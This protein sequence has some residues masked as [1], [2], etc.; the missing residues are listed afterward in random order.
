ML[1]EDGVPQHCDC[2]TGLM[3][4]IATGDEEPRVAAWCIWCGIG[5][6]DSGLMLLRAGQAMTDVAHL[7]VTIP[8]YPLI[9]KYDLWSPEC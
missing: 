7:E 4:T 5:Y 2:L 1:D 6:G 9:G 8:M 3:A